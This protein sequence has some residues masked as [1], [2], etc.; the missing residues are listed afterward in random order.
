MKNNKL[1]EVIQNIKSNETILKDLLSF[2]GAIQK[3]NNTHYSCVHCSSSDALS[4]DKKNNTYKCFSCNTFGNAIDLVID[5]ENLTFI[6]AIKYIANMYNIQLPQIEYTEEE[7]EKYK[8]I[9]K[10][11]KEL[12]KLLYKLDLELQRQDLDINKKFEISC[13]KEHLQNTN[14]QDVEI[15]NYANYKANEVIEIDKYISEHKSSIINCIASAMNNNTNLLIAPTGS[16][17]T[18]TIINTLKELNIKALFILPNSS[19]VEQVMTEYQV[20]GAYGNELNAKEEIKKGNIIAMTWDKTKQLKDIDLTEYIIIIDEIHQTFSDLYRAEAIQALYSITSKC[21]GRIDITAT[22]NKLD[23]S[24]YDY[25]TEY[26]QKEQTN[27]NLKVYDNI[28][29]KTIIDIINNSKKSAMLM[30]NSSTLTYISNNINKVNQVVTSDNKDSNNLYNNIINKS[31]MCECE[32]LLNTSVITAG[33]NIYEKDITD[34]IVV[35][36]K[37]VA[38]IKQYVAR[39]RDLKECNVHIF[40]KYKEENNI[41]S[42]EYLVR[43]NIE[44][45]NS[46]IDSLNSSLNKNNEF[47]LVASSIRA[48]RLDKDETNIYFDKKDKIHKLNEFSIR[49]KTYTKYYNSRAIHSFKV[50]LK[51]YFNSVEIVN[52]VTEQLT[53]E[54]KEHNR[55]IKENKEQ[56][57]E[58]LSKYKEILVGYTDISK[59]KKL[60]YELLK[61]YDLNNINIDKIKEQ[62][63]LLDIDSIVK[64]NRLTNMLDLY[65]EYVL[66]ESFSTNLAFELVKL[67][68]K[69]RSTVFAK[70]QN[71]IFRALQNEIIVNNELLENKL[72]KFITDRFT[73]GTSYTEEHLKILSNEIKE[74]FKLDYSTTRIANMLNQIYVI[75]KSQIRG[76]NRISHNF[77]KNIVHMLLPG[78]RISVNRIERYIN[79]QDILSILD[80]ENDKSLCNT[81]AKRKSIH[82]KEV[83]QQQLDIMKEL[84]AVFK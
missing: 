75:N 19:N 71:V 47:D 14:K 59:N 79:L 11:K 39:F 61:Y 78:K 27:Y 54:L 52:D 43:Q 70:V 15:I 69:K 20:L 56:A 60:N 22:P 32:V 40:N 67:N 62:Y 64:A 37:D 29:T 57:I 38:T 65:S 4:I 23:F 21:K 36:I 74:E 25:I 35:N 72:Y 49:G 31:S 13:L 80:L 17:K 5:K 41:Y 34:I 10:D 83:T 1:T 50:L 3:K 7:K 30:N 53:E 46:V 77:Y 45:Y 76:G 42:I 12:D 16:G 24:I 8:K 48:I 73:I 2:Y 82:K 66:K 6:N 81:I 33:V 84:R 63:K 9:K 44:K 28:D 68:R 55:N 18:Y 58:L 26:K 51:E